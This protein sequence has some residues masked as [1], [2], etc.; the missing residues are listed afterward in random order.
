VAPRKI[1][2]HNGEPMEDVLSQRGLEPSWDSLIPIETG[3]PL[4]QIGP[5][6]LAI[7]ERNFPSDIVQD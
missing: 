6:Y 2:F 4:D 5:D 7:L 1:G 3:V